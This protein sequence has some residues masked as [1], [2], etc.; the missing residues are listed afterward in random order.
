MSPSRTKIA[1]VS[2][3]VFL[4]GVLPHA[5]VA[6]A[7]PCK[8]LRRVL[9]GTSGKDHIVGNAATT[10]STAGARRTACSAARATT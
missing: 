6:G 8:E 4:V 2:L 9:Q 3:A 5:G 7:R 1:I 10:R